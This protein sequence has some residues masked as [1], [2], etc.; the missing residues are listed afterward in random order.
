MG[1]TGNRRMTGKRDEVT[2]KPGQFGMM[3]PTM[4][5]I[6]PLQRC[7]GRDHQLPRETVHSDARSARPRSDGIPTR[8]RL[9]PVRPS[10]GGALIARTPG[11]PPPEAES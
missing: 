4:I 1:Y 6:I 7:N 9:V 5:G 3:F 2:E 11:F 8:P 10:I